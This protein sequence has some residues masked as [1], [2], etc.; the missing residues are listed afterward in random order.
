[1]VR[2]LDERPP[3]VAA[4]PAAVPWQGGPTEPAP[5]PRLSPASTT[6]NS[7]P[8]VTIED[9]IEAAVERA[10]Q[11]M[12]GPYLAK[13]C[14]PEPAVYTVA[15]TAVVMQVS[16]DTVARLVKRGVLP[17]VP[18]L[19]GKVLIPR[20]AVQKLVGGEGE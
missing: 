6:D 3:G 13:L 10:L 16:E 1:M 8:G 2:Q 20:A 17:R 15:H 11:R 19:D 5:R 7:R 4:R 18:H 12:L 9:Q 14:A